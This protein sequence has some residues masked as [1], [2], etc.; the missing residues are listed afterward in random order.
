MLKRGTGDRRIQY[1][2][3][4]SIN[5]RTCIDTKVYAIKEKKTSFVV[6][7]AVRGFAAFTLAAAL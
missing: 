4:A 5:L 7:K 1:E 2:A 3:R 6:C